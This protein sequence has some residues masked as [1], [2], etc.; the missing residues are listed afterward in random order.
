VGIP[1]IVAAGEKLSVKGLPSMLL[2]AI[3]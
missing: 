1:G 2:N 3:F